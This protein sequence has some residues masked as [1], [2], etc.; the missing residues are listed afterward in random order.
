MKKIE[1]LKAMPVIG[2]AADDFDRFKLAHEILTSPDE[3]KED[4]YEALREIDRTTG[5]PTVEP[6]D[7]EDIELYIKYA[8]HGGN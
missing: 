5:E 6:V 2:N 4:K 8:V 1:Q 3:T 7:D